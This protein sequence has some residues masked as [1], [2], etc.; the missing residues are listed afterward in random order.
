MDIYPI[1]LGV[2]VFLLFVTNAISLIGSRVWHQ[3]QHE[4]GIVRAKAQE[5][6]RFLSK[7]DHEL[8]NPITAIRF[9]LAN[10]KAI[11]TEHEQ[12]L[13]IQN[14]EGQTLRIAELIT[15]LRKISEFER[16]AIEHIPVALGDL[17]YE[18][19]ALVESTPHANG[20]RVTLSVEPANLMM[21]GDKYL[22]LIA[23]Y[24]VLDNGFKFTEGAVTATV[25]EENEMAVIEIIDE[26][27]G[28]TDSELP[29]VWEELYRSSRTQH[30]SGSGLGLA[31]VRAIVERHAGSA[32]VESTPESGTTV[33]L[34]LPAMHDCEEQ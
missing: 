17:M 27:P 13:M 4:A 11:T 2:V 26:G 3:R 15:N 30:I 5:L 19:A 14:L 12:L 24:N 7:L 33:R 10:L 28:M 1:T 21:C 18:A 32:T 16:L 8:K 9:G 29:H 20:R 25:W 6:Q 23:I 34:D 31:M 22:L